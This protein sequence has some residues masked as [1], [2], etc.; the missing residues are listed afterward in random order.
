MLGL[1]ELFPMKLFVCLQ[2]MRGRPSAWALASRLEQTFGPNVPPLE[3]WGSLSNPKV[4]NPQYS[5][6]ELVKNEHDS[7]S[8]MKKPTGDLM[9]T[10]KKISVRGQSRKMFPRPIW[11]MDW[12]C[13]SSGRVSP[14][15]A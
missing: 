8:A 9:V 12:R 13:G 14:L 4:P 5:K 3:T 7:M 1:L 10:I 15:Q 2:R 6:S 11:K